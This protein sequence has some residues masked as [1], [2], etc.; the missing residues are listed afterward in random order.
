[1]EGLN[2]IMKKAVTERVFRGVEVEEEVSFNILQ[3]AD[4]TILMGGGCWSNLWCI[5]SIL[6]SFELV[7]RLKGGVAQKNFIHWV[8]WEKVCLPKDKGGLGVKNIELFNI[9]LFRKWEWRTMNDRSSIWS[10][11]IGFRY[12]AFGFPLLSRGFGRGGIKIRFAGETYQTL[13]VIVMSTRTRTA[14]EMI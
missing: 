12:C 13:V 2:G 9:S 7:S 8:S 10:S 4:D 6:R 1:M 5:K 11:L 3:F 14:L